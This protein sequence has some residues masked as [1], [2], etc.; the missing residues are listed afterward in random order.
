MKR[1]QKQD[2]LLL[3]DHTN[4]LFEFEEFLFEIFLMSLP[5]S[6]SGHVGFQLLK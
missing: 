1:Q 3:L 2:D 6:G 4:L 5:Q